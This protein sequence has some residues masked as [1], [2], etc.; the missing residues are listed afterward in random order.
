M[1]RRSWCL[2]PSEVLADEDFTRTEV[3]V[4]GVIGAKIFTEGSFHYVPEV[5]KA[6]GTT[7][8]KVATTIEKAVEKNYLKAESHENRDIYIEGREVRG[9]FP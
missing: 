3:L 1:S 5:T 7:E 9:F 4:Y 2:V 6:L 8:S